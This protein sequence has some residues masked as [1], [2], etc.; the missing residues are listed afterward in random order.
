MAD[1]EISDAATWPW[2]ARGLAFAASGLGAV[3]A[4]Y[5]LLVADQRQELASL[6]QA[7]SALEESLVAKTRALG[8][9]ESLAEHLSTARKALADAMRPLPSAPELP[10]LIENLSGAALDSGLAIDSIHVAAEQDHGFY[11][12]TPIALVLTGSYHQFGAFAAAAANLA[13]L[14]T[15]HDFEIE[16]RGGLLTMSLAARAISAA[17]GP[18]PAAGAPW[19]WPDRVTYTA[20][21][22]SPFGEGRSGL[23]EDVL[24][25]PVGQDQLLDFALARLEMVGVLASRNEAHALVRDPVGT[26]HRVKPGGPLGPARRP[27]D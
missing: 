5:V 14:L 18:E 21:G 8:S 26:V 9:A 15:F 12:A 1:F 10:A 23:A 6:R 11:Q 19:L 22:R 7:N 4:G 3:F 2:W 27:R 17:G 20:S 16:R 24:A 25:K 13:R